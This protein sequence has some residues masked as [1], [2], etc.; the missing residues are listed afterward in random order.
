MFSFGEP[1]LPQY[2]PPVE[3]EPPA[4]E[5]D[6]IAPSSSRANCVLSNFPVGSASITEQDDDVLP[7]FD[8]FVCT[9]NGKN[10][11]NVSV[12]AVY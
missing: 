9:A 1:F 2:V 3:G 7:R 11:T 5:H 4:P 10:G 8:S 6:Q 12:F